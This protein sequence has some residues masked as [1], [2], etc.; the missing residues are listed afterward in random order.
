MTVVMAMIV[1]FMPTAATLMG[2]GMGVVMRLLLFF[3]VGM[4]VSA[5][6]TNVGVLVCMPMPMVVIMVM[7]MVM[8]VIMIAAVVHF[9]SPHGSEIEDAQQDEADAPGQRHRAE[10]TFRHGRKVVRDAATNVEV[11]HHTTPE[12]EEGD[13]DKMKHGFLDSH[14]SAG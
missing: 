2:L 5:A 4:V 12:N 8:V 13:A 1:M 10:P 11:E 14:G 9:L 7:V 6:A 3:F